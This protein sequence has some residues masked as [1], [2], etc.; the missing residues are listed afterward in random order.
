ML[1]VKGRGRIY[2][3]RL[4]KFLVY[5]V[6]SMTLS[7]LSNP[8]KYQLQLTASPNSPLTFLFHSVEQSWQ[9]S[10]LLHKLPSVVLEQFLLPHWLTVAHCC[11]PVAPEV[12]ESCEIVQLRRMSPDQGHCL[13]ALS[14]YTLLQATPSSRI[15][16]KNTHTVHT[17]PHTVAYMHTRACTHVRTHTHLGIQQGL[18][19]LLV[20]IL[21]VQH[22]LLQ[23]TDSTADLVIG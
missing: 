13:V 8:L 18:V 21:L 14:C 20:H 22:L 1:I 2:S 3:L 16:V 5:L 12:V 11:V 17:Y 15:V 6:K 9:Y 23:L 4:V 19:K 7:P 10:V